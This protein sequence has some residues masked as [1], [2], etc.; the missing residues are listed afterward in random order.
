MARIVAG[1]ARRINDRRRHLSTVWWM[2]ADGAAGNDA[3]AGSAGAL[4]DGDKP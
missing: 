4:P 2:A 3:R 1:P